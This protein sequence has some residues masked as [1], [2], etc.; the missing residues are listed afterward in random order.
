MSKFYI[1]TPIYYPSGKF[2]VGHC[3]CTVVA[4]VI[5]R[6]NR[7]KGNDVFFL[8]GTDDHG[9][10]IERKALELNLSP[11]EYVDS[12]VNN[13]KELW[14]TL[15]ISYDRFIRTTDE[16]HV[17]CV[18]Y[19]FEKLYNS[20]DIYKSEYE[21]KY[22]TPCESFFTESQLIDGKC[23]DCGREVEIV[24]EESYF[25]KLSK[26]EDK[27]KK[28]FEDN[29]DFLEP[30]NRKN[31]MFNSFLNK[32]LD[33]LCVSRT[34]FKWGVPVTFDPKHVVYVWIDA[35]SNYISALGYGTDN[36]LMKKFWPADLHLV[37]KEITRFHSIIW[38]AMLMALDLPLPK[39]VF[40]HGWLLVDGKK[41]S[42]SFGNYKDPREYIKYSSVDSLRY[43]LLKE[44]KLGFDGDFN[45]EDY[46][47]KINS[48]L[49]NDLG[50][51]VSR[52]LSMSEKYN[53]GV[54]NNNSCE[55]DTDTKLYD[56][57]KNN[58][59]KYIENMDNLKLDNAL[60]CIMEIVSYSNKYVDLNEP[61]LLGKDSSKSDRLDKVLYN[62][63]ETLRIIAIMLKPFMTTVPDKILT[64]LGC[65]N[66]DNNLDSI[67]NF[68]MIKNNTICK[69]T[70]ILFPRI[71]REKIM[72]NK[73]NI[74]ENKENIVENEIKKDY[75]IITID[76]FKKVKLKT[77]TIT[78]VENIEKSDKLFKLTVD[79]GTEVRTIVSGLIGY[80]TKEELINKKVI[81]V[82]NL[83]AAKLRG[84]ESNGMIL[85]AEDDEV[86]SLLQCD[87]NMNNGM[88]IH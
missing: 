72:E 41:I 75:E 36:E 26:Y 19:I 45:E 63:A 38:P 69:K 46:I 35:L 27:L 73:E 39:K 59:K 28:Y 1:T 13:T 47:T 71:E 24:K 3:Y 6:Y 30:E 86:V 87:K 56:L 8:T 55:N 66:L 31:E 60:S 42:K 7:L 43:Y 16:D 10:K 53:K 80:Y 20:G 52:T 77:G 5:A 4:D 78:N 65:D 22:C 50:N 76:E 79:L 23:P 57:I 64:D 51:L 15:D 82:V 58:T 25:F 48:D 33:D 40:G 37:G 81:V 9:Q 85:A 83:K 74:V 70:C 21:G 14:E 49:S 68:G 34:S 88:E 61:W 12:I 62:L 29:K 2:H 44:I 11:K 32:G 67:N 84:V 54:L 17:K 18:Q